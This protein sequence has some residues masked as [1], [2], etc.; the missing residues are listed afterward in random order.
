[1]SGPEFATV[2]SPFINQRLGMGWKMITGNF[3]DPSATGRESFRAILIKSDLRKVIKRIKYR[4]DQP[5]L[6]DD[7]ISQAVSVLEPI[8]APTFIEANHQATELLMK[9]AAVEGCPTGTRTARRPST[10]ST[11]NTPRTTRSR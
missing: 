7:P 5:W 6:D 2:E 1:M 11:G 8:A 9:G 3:E 4:D 10:V